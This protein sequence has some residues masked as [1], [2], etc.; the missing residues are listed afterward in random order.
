VK[1]KSTISAGP[2][3]TPLTGATN[4]SASDADHAEAACQVRRGVIALFGLQI[5]YMAAD[6]GTR[7]G[8]TLQLLGFC[9]A[10]LLLLALAFAY[11]FTS[12]FH[13]RW[14][15]VTLTYCLAL[16]ATS[17]ISSMV[18][19]AAGWNIFLVI[20]FSL[21]CSVW[22]PWGP[23]WQALLNL[24]CLVSLSIATGYGSTN[25]PLVWYHWVALLGALMLSPVAAWYLD[26][27][28]RRTLGSEAQ[29]RAIIDGAFDGIVTM[30]VEGLITSWNPKAESIFGWSRDEAIGRKLFELVISK[31]DRPFFEDTINSTGQLRP[32]DQIVELMGIHRDGRRFPLE[33]ALSGLHSEGRSLFVVFARDITERRWAEEQRSLLASIVESA[34]DAIFSV[35]L[36]GII[37]SWNPGAEK[38]YRYATEEIIGRPSC[39]LVPPN[40]LSQGYELMERLAQDERVQ[41]LET[42][43][44]RKDGALVEV[45]LTASPMYS[46]AGRIAGVAVITRDITE[47]KRVEHELRESEEKFRRIFDA[48]LDAITIVTFSEGRYVAVNEEF[49]QLSGYARDEVIGRTSKEIG[50]W[51]NREDA[52]RTVGEL[53]QKGI[54]RNLE[55]AFRSKSGA[56]IASSFSALV[57]NFHGERCVL[58]FVRDLGDR[59]RAEQTRAL[60]ASI[61]ESADEAVYSANFAQEITTW[62]PGAERLYGY[63]AEE[64]VG[65]SLNVLVPAARLGEMD[66]ITFGL[67]AGPGIRHYETQ[68]MRKDG[69]LVDVAMTVS[70]IFSAAGPLAGVSVIAHD[71]TERKRVERELRESEEKFRKVFDASLD[72][73]S[74]NSFSDGTYVDV[75]ENFIKCMGYE[76]E[77]VLGKAPRELRVW[78]KHEDLATAM[79]ELR[80]KGMAYNLEAEFVAKGGAHWPGLFSAVVVNFN[81][82]PCVLSFSRD[83]TER[84]RAELEL[85]EA[86]EQALAASRAKSEFLATM[87]HE[88]RTPMN[89]IIG[90]GELLSESALTSEQR[91][92]VRIAKSAGNALLS[93]IDNILDLSKIE[94]GH[95]RLEEIDFDLEE[96]VEDTVASFAFRADEKNLEL[97]SQIESALPRGFKGDPT[98]MR[99]VLGNLIGNAVK[100]TGQGEVVVSVERDPDASDPGRL[101]FS[102]RDTGIGIPAD[103]AQAVFESFTQVDNSITRRYGGSGLGLTICKRLVEAM[104]GRIWLESEHGKGAVFY[105]TVD[106]KVSAQGQRRALGPRI[107]LRDVGILVADDNASQRRI[108]RELLEARGARVAEAADYD[109]ALVELRRAKQA[110]AGYRLML[111]DGCLAEG[112]K[113][114][115]AGRNGNGHAMVGAV[116][117]TLKSSNLNHGLE[118]ARR[119]EIELYLVKPIAQRDLF[120]AIEATLVKGPSRFDSPLPEAVKH[121][122]DRRT[123]RI[124]LAEDSED[125]RVLVEAYLKDTLYHV[126]AAENGEIAVAKFTNGKY[127]LVLMDMQMPVLDGY[128]AVKTIREWERNAAVPRTPII[129]LTAYALKEEVTK[130]LD[131]GCDSHL[132]KP[133][134][135]KTLMDAILA[136]TQDS[137]E[138][139][140]THVALVDPELAPLLPR[141]LKRKRDD[142][143]TIRDHLEQ[144]DYETVRVLG[145]N[146]KGEGGGYGLDALT[147]IGSSIEEAA[148]VKDPEQLRTLVEAL[149]TYLNEVEVVYG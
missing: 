23:R 27:Y 43:R 78:A 37:N 105:F 130:S 95:L 74:I 114:E 40:L 10:N 32:S 126:D 31:D 141:F 146:M 131:A 69:S 1:I 79:A 2:E 73:I 111:L 85:I 54:V 120:T 41:Y 39:I 61:V 21:G 127:D 24:F 116:I 35:T 90:M 59:K 92:Y 57:I 13:Q 91:G 36:E 97:L 115:S 104:G 60:L 16:L 140:Q 108:L 122:L 62:N 22:I 65:R 149:A 63:S 82:Q 46:D 25:D 29:T 103:K 84:K 102:V 128:T 96:L 76:R 49:V 70:P 8:S 119:S 51:A 47:Q 80:T 101:R 71:I 42:Q 93:L 87:S 121:A 48:S 135:K 14:R 28:R 99:Q 145:H 77:E 18:S 81:D 129:A 11:S 19:H 58:S 50:I 94:G 88:I 148:K 132:S 72:S 15:L 136:A 64:V 5:L 67:A 106:L 89:A 98:R 86:R 142:I 68:R 9:A 109:T 147:K 38:L 52:K 75:N 100:F 53:A 34:E 20:L 3:V 117:L 123:L 144:Q 55:V 138:N 56:L 107:D 30:D 33:L 44:L 139:H 118:Q 137:R 112:R 125:N 4:D 110:G 143:L 45:C 66:Q 134:K 17:A 133:I 124:L 6:A 113:L 7:S 83:I 12:S 26:L